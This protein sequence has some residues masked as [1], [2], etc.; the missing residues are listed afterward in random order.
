MRHQ[1]IPILLAAAVF[2]LPGFAQT[3]LVDAISGNDG[4]GV[5]AYQTLQAAVNAVLANP[6]TPDVVEL[7]T[8][9]PHVQT[10]T[11]QITAVGTN[12]TIRGQGGGLARIV[13][14]NFIESAVNTN[15]S[16][17]I[18]TATNA[19]VLFQDFILIPPPLS[20]VGVAGA[21]GGDGNGMNGIVV[22]TDSANS[23]VTFRNLVVTGNNNANQPT[24]LDG[25]V[26]WRP[27]PNATVWPGACL[28][29]NANV[30]MTYNV[31]NCV[32]SQSTDQ[33]L[34]VNQEIGSA[35]TVPGPA[36]VVSGTG[37][38]SYAD[39]NALHLNAASVTLSAAQ[40]RGIEIFNTN[41]AAGGSSAVQ[42]EKADTVLVQNLWIHDIGNGNTN[43]ALYFLGVGGKNTTIRNCH[44][45]RITGT[46]IR[47]AF[48]A[49]NAAQMA[50]ASWLIEDCTLDYSG[51]QGFYDNN[52]MTTAGDAPDSLIF[53][54]CS[55]RNNA[56][57]G[58]RPRAWRSV[59]VEDCWFTDN[60]K[61][62][63]IGSNSN[64]ETDFAN[65]TQCFLDMESVGRTDTSG[66]VE[67][68]LFENG[69]N[70]GVYLF[71]FNSTL[72]NC[73]SR[74]NGGP[75]IGAGSR[76]ARA[77]VVLIEDCTSQFDA[78][79]PTF[80]GALETRLC[81][82]ATR[83]NDI[84]FRR[85]FVQGAALN[86][87]FTLSEAY[88]DNEINRLQS[89]TVVDCA[90]TAVRLEAATIEITD[91]V[92]LN[93]LGAGFRKQVNAGDAGKPSQ[94][95]GPITITNCL[96]QQ[97]AD[98]GVTTDFAI[99]GTVELR[100]SI[101]RDCGSGAVIASATARVS[102][103]WFLNNSVAGL[104]VGFGPGPNAV[105]DYVANSSFLGN[106]Q[107]GIYIGEAAGSAVGMVTN[108][109]I[110]N[111]PHGIHVEGIGITAPISVSDTIIGGVGAT[112][113][114]AD[115]FLFTPGITVTYSSLILQGAHALAAVKDDAGSKVTLGAGVIDSDPLFLS[116][117]PAAGAD[118]L[119]VDSDY[120]GGRGS[121]GSD[122]RGSGRY[123]GGTTGIL[124]WRQF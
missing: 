97:C 28:R 88:R 44:F 15:A 118:F 27:D 77:D 110:L 107:A 36:L 93:C 19:T 98:E 24:S 68:C 75:G 57:N 95:S 32:L 30:G 20:V 1:L 78:I 69:G 92:F 83:G 70:Y 41:Q 73:V 63:G 119:A 14:A 90:S 55:V 21:V 71:A 64:Y 48:N 2:A 72:R 25:S 124:S 53:R 80:T 18:L 7:A 123:V 50:G 100:D 76:N 122:L 81:A 58:I 5:P 106:G 99:N 61:Q 56:A 10:A 62:N 6:A 46:T 115:A 112:G 3:V 60:G 33:V 105:L 59:R 11:V 101:L 82:V 89:V 12:L 35:T 121:G 116:I 67:R 47:T 51:Q 29:C 13:G 8:N 52:L 4:T 42:I 102:D 87:I 38:F 109:T 114:F 65:G 111:S 94:E 91:S 43:R 66:L 37:R 79:N 117:D 31:E 34:N 108:C 54:R 113:I 86:A 17:L 120:F 96:F 26:D 84:L 39:D 45:E 23:T 103:C 22:H 104:R 16:A 85:L 74:N 40:P 49:P 9:A